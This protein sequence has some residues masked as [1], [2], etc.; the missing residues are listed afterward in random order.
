MASRGPRFAIVL[1]VAASLIIVAP[2]AGA[3]ARPPAEWVI[4]PR[5][6]AMIVFDGHTGGS[7]FRVV[8]KALDTLNVKASFFV[9]GQW[10][11]EYKKVARR[12]V[13]DGHLLGNRGDGRRS[14]TTLNEKKL[15]TSIRRATRTLRRLGARPR[16]F[17]RAPRGER[18]VKVL[19]IAGGMGYRSVRWTHHPGG[20]PTRKVAKAVLGRLRRGSIVSLDIWRRSHRRALPRIV[21]GIRDRGF[22]PATI[23]ALKGAP[24][25]RWDVTLG[26][27]SSG[28]QVVYLQQRLTQLGYPVKGMDGAFGERTQQ[29]VFAFQKVHGLKRDGV[30]S[31]E[32]M[33][34]I[35]VARRAKVRKREVKRYVEVDI[36]RQVLFEVRQSR[37]F[38][39]LPISSGNEKNYKQDGVKYKAHTPRGKFRI[40]RRISGWRKS[41]LGRLWHPSYFKGG[42]AIHGSP[43]VPVY[44]ASHGCVRIPMWLTKGFNRR[45][46]VGTR[47][48]IH[49]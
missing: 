12:I 38:K 19:R 39:V 8:L 18:D 32:E 40:E 24:A 27:G 3:A 10:A 44:P 23:E 26:P 35:A 48:F 13:R 25:I 15:R 31:P 17:L 29:G 33:A 34:T 6:V 41:R 14:F 22:E 36:S 28:D 16:P 4:G 2:V 45:N 9:S 49:K 7:R 20:G 5:R 30:V 42:Y 37:V 21:S 47:V 46:P 43:T 1:A 11:R